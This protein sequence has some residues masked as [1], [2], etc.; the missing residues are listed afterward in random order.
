MSYLQDK[1]KEALGLNKVDSS[2]NSFITNWSPNSVRCIILAK[3]YILVARHLGASVGCVKKTNLDMAL[4]VQDLEETTA[5][6]Y[7][8]PK[9]N[10]VLSKRSFSCLEEFYI[11][12]AYLDYPKM[13][14]IQGYIK[15]LAKST[16]RIR[17]FGHGSFPDRGLD[18]YMNKV[19]ADNMKNTGYCLA[20]D[21]NFP[22]KLVSIDIGNK[23]WYSNYLLRPS[24]YKLDYPKGDLALHFAK[25]ERDYSKISASLEKEVKDKSVDEQ[26]T[27]IAMR[28]ERDTEV[29]HKIDRMLEVLA[30]NKSDKVCNVAY[31]EW[32]RAIS[33]LS[34]F[35]GLSQSWVD[36]VF[37][38]DRYMKLVYQRYN[39][40]YTGSKGV[41]PDKVTE[42]YTSGRGFID[43]KS[44]LDDFCICLTDKLIKLG[45]EDMVGLSLSMNGSSI[46][47]GNFR[48]KYLR[49]N[50]DIEDTDGYFLYLS[51]LIGYRL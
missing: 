10:V 7:G 1:L 9:L 29:F 50:S 37:G 5:K 32:G 25:I 48:M 19:Y 27:Y 42:V 8:N 14:D 43:I 12:S 22:V 38:S 46:P 35:E 34:P 45:M 41:N 33:S 3:N 6:N 31:K 24:F 39:A 44:I 51:D 26:I 15:D 2:K 28:D 36:R 23:E 4:V 30:R 17:Y 47:D 18:D 13:I 20:K 21:D 49:N 40:V 11:D 16:S